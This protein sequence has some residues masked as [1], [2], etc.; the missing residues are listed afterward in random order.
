MERSRE[1]TRVNQNYTLSDLGHTGEGLGLPESG[2]LE[3]VPQ[4]TETQILRKGCHP[5]AVNSTGA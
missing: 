3:M 2:N 5:A 1:S 4:R